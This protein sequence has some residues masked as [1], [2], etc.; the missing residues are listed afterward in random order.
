[1][2]NHAPASVDRFGAFRLPNDLN[3]RASNPTPVPEGVLVNAVA[4]HLFQLG[5]DDIRRISAV[6]LHHQSRREPSVP[7]HGG[8]LGHDHYRMMK[9][10]GAR[11]GGQ[12]SCFQRPMCRPGKRLAIAT[13]GSCLRGGAKRASAGTTPHVA[14]AHPVRKPYT[15]PPGSR[16]APTRRNAGLRECYPDYTQNSRIFGTYGQGVRASPDPAH[17]LRALGGI[18]IRR[19]AEI[20]RRRTLVGRQTRVRASGFNWP[21]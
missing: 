8:N 9:A 7:I 2:T 18:G 11:T 10:D 3:D 4:L 14:V 13:V 20:W 16:I 19:R 17:G 6:P 5:R 21:V 15:K 1:M 12:V